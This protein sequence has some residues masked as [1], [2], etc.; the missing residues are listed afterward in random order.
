[1]INRAELEAAVAQTS[2][3]DLPALVGAL[4]A[5]QAEALARLATPAAAAPPSAS[6]LVPLTEGWA[7]AHGY[8]LETA[9]KLACTGQLAG[10]RPAPSR[11]K[12]R[13]RRWLVPATLRAAEAR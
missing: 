5:A 12:G 10:A 8:E 4:A 9:R 3:E 7:R 13:R 2:R 1:V 6:E 11:G